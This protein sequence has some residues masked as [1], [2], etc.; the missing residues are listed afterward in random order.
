M[1]KT[2]LLGLISFLFLGCSNPTS[3]LAH[4]PTLTDAMN[5]WLA[6]HAIVKP[7]LSGTSGTMNMGTDTVVA[8]DGTITLRIKYLDWAEYLFQ[9]SDSSKGIVD[10]SF[11][12][13]RYTTP[14]PGWVLSKSVDA[15]PDNSTSL[16]GKWMNISSGTSTYLARQQ[17]WTFQADHSLI[18]Y[19]SDTGISLNGVWQSFGMSRLIIQYQDQA[20]QIY[21]YGLAADGLSFAVVVSLGPYPIWYKQP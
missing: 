18:Y 6:S 16:L 21:Q 11:M 4:I 9:Y 17:I 19:D 8:S 7:A 3:Y 2:F 10:V 20:A 13:S 15:S 5:D 12:H 1:R 14:D